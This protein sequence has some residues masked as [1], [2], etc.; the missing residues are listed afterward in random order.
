MKLNPFE[1]LPEIGNEIKG[2]SFIHPLE[3]VTMERSV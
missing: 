3:K 2:L 1:S